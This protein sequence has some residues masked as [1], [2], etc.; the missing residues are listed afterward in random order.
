MSISDESSE[1]PVRIPIT[2]ELDLHTFRANEIGELIPEY[3]REAQALGIR[4]VR[5][6]HG[7]G[8]GTL[9]KGVHTLL[10][11]LPDLVSSYHMADQTAGGWGATWAKLTPSPRELLPE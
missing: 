7:K 11:Q 4:E 6:V 2:N 3:L 1:D 5:I 10:D 8:T 9:R